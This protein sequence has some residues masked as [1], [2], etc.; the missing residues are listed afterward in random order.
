[1]VDIGVLKELPWY[2]D[3]PWA[4][5]TFRIPKKTG[6]ISSITDFRKLN[7]WVKV[8]PF[9]LP[10]INETLQKLK[11]FKSATALDLSLGFYSI[12][13]DK[14]SQKLCSTILQWV[15]TNT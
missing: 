10:R 12:L 2:D 13:L 5:P 7:K 1:M 6:D 9:P 4:S 14:E 8:D 15:N 3:S 11:R